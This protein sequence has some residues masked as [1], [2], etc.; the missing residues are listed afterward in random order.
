[1]IIEGLKHHKNYLAFTI[2]AWICANNA[3]A[4]HAIVF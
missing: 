4:S 2:K 3:I 1:M